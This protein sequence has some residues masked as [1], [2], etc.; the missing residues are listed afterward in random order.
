MHK[1][2]NIFFKIIHTDIFIIVLVVMK[3]YFILFIICS[4]KHQYTC[5]RNIRAVKIYVTHKYPYTTESESRHKEHNWRV[6][7]FFNTIYMTI[8]KSFKSNNKENSYINLSLL[9]VYWK[10]KILNTYVLMLRTPVLLVCNYWSWFRFLDNCF[11][12]LR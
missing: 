10:V 7:Q 1:C 4:Q 6:V 2:I 5:V 11:F 3:F 12:S 9:D 8:V